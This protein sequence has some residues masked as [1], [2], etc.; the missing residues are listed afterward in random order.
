MSELDPLTETW[1]CLVCFW[2][3]CFGEIIARDTLRCPKCDSSHLHPA[4]ITRRPPPPAL[5]LEAEHHRPEIVTKARVAKAVRRQR[6]D[7]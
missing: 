3:G 4:D 1:C 2:K 6:H 7:A 5:L